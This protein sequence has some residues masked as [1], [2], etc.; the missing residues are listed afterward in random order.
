MMDNTQRKPGFTPGPWKWWTSCS[1]RRLKTAGR[2]EKPICEPYVARDGHPDLIITEEDMALIAAA[3]EL[4]E[5]LSEMVDMVETV[6]A[7]RLEE[8]CAIDTEH[9]LCPSECYS[10]GCIRDKYIRARTALSRAN[11]GEK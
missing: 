7:D 8:P 4:Y 1:W 6:F 11:G 3:P 2:N 9:D 10:V 5:A